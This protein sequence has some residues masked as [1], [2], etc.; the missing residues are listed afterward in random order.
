VAGDVP[1]YLPD[2][3][4]DMRTCLFGETYR[5][6]VIAHNR[7]TTS[8]KAAPKVPAELRG[9]LEFS[10]KMGFV[11]GGESFSFQMKFEP[12]QQL[13]QQCKK[14]LKHRDDLVRAA[15]AAAASERG[16]DA[17]A[18]GVAYAPHITTV[19]A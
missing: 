4:I 13:L 18:A 2:D 16:E 14:Y 11:Q 8:F 6:V 7:S 17:E 1:I 15:A 10:P 9:A 5:H 12:Q 19:F 3:S